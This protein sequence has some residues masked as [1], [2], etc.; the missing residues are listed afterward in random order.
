MAWMGHEPRILCIRQ[1]GPVIALVHRRQMVNKGNVDTF[2][3]VSNTKEEASERN[4]QNNIL[5]LTPLHS[6]WRLQKYCFWANS[7]SLKLQSKYLS[8]TQSLLSPGQCVHSGTGVVSSFGKGTVLAPMS[9]V[10]ACNRCRMAK[11]A[12]GNEMTVADEI[13]GWS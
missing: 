13:H 7:C 6:N 8:S 1:S 2:S 5:S 10:P 4:L 9:H 11:H 12:F 3:M